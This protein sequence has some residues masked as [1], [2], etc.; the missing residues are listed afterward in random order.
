MAPKRLI[1]AEN[2]ES[3]ESASVS[4]SQH[5]ISG[6]TRITQ[7]EKIT[8]TFSWM[9]TRPPATSL[10]LLTLLPSSSK[11]SIT[12]LHL[13][14]VQIIIVKKKCIEIFINLRFF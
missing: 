10:L 2:K 8:K 4:E 3:G 1:N 6:L 5:S 12:S 14:Y 7:G 11:L 13:W 9:M